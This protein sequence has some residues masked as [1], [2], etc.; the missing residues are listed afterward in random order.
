MAETFA[1][2]CIDDDE[3]TLFIT[4]LSLEL[5]HAMLAT[6]VRS[7]EE[8]LVLL[9]TDTVIDCIL[10]DEHM[11][12][13]SGT[14]LLPRIRALAGHERT[15]V[16]FLTASVRARDLESY[17]AHGARGTIAKPFDPLTLA[18]QVRRLL[19]GNG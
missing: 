19:V 9:D 8:A 3:D 15:P 17:R 16:I 6:T 10:L 1:I 13:M 18:S 7:P 11:P 4:Q 14:E 5:D 2:L 12:T